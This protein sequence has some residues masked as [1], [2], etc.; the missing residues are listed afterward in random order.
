ML[1]WL[2]AVHIKHCMHHWGSFLLELIQE[3]FSQSG[4]AYHCQV[5][6]YMENANVE[7]ALSFF[8]FLIFSSVLP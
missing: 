6:L 2:A 8:F 7:E 3:N 4:C 5:F 1:L